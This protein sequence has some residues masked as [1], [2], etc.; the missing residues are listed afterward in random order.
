MKNT[1]N[2][3]L[4]PIGKEEIDRAR[5]VLMQYKRDKAN[6]ERKIIDNEQWWKLRHWEQ[7]RRD[8]SEYKPASA[9]LW[10]VIVS[11]H[12]DAMDSFPEPVLLPR[13]EDDTAEAK[14]LSS[15]IPIILDQN[16]FEEVYSQLQWYKLKQGT[17]VYG[18][19]WDS[20]KNNGL[21]DVSIKKVDVLSLFW[22]SGICDIQDSKNLFYVT[23][24]DRDEL[25]RLYPELDKKE[26]GDGI[27]IAQYIYD[28]HV[29]TSNK[30]PVVDWYYRKDTLLHYCKFTGDQL[31]FATENHPE[32]YPDGWYAHGMYP[33]VFDTMFSIEGTPCGYGYI[34]VCKETQT[35]I[36]LINHSVIN[37]A[38]LASKP[39]YFIRGDGSVNEEEFADWTKDFVH[40]NGNLGRDSIL[41]IDVNPVNP[42]YV[43]LL[44]NKIDELKETS[45]NRDSTNGGTSSGV[46][47]ASAIAAMQEAGGKI[48]RDSNRTSYR[49]YRQVIYHCIELI[50]QFY[51]IP[52]QFRI[53]GDM[54]K[55]GFTSYSNVGLRPKYQGESFGVDLGYRVPEFDIEVCAQRSNPYTRLSQ[56]ELALQFYNLGFFDPARADAALACL[57]MMDF[58]RKESVMQ[59]ISKK[60]SGIQTY[61]ATNAKLPSPDIREKAMRYAAESVLP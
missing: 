41:Q 36:D 28:D 59:S 9:W 48:S 7:L 29:D 61:G 30:V 13:A 45:G 46:T 8:K 3:S 44:N 21:G 1:D 15:V 10:N 22:E 42:I 24:K 51:D 53:L 19:F 11:K 34:D 43:T 58:S 27:D 35:Q 18:I 50:R 6:L 17:G 32:L 33:F 14:K 25:C 26:L 49:A 40:T 38:M 20:F 47:A 54:G 16:D 60:A 57:E 56:N 4:V 12:A 5:R 52:R 23:L 37:N 55:I 39:R 2:E 31:I